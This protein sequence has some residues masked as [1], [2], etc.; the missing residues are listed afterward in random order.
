MPMG[1]ELHFLVSQYF[2]LLAMTACTTAKMGGR[3][4]GRKAPFAT[5]LFK[6]L[7]GLV[8]DSGPIFE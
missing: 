5:I 1:N 3:T 6:K 8:F 4:F 7:G 2:F